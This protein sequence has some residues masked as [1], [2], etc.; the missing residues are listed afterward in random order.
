MQQPIRAEMLAPF[1]IVRLGNDAIGYMLSRDDEA[2]VAWIDTKSEIIPIPFGVFVQRLLNITDFACE[3]IRQPDL[4]DTVN[5][6]I[7]R[8]KVIR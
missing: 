8:S 1:D 7:Q 5:S 6:I 3:C 4:V 2:G